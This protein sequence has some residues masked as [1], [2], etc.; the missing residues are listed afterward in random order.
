MPGSAEPQVHEPG[1]RIYGS[2][3]A[4]LPDLLE[5][6]LAAPAAKVSEHPPIPEAPGIYLFS[7]PGEAGGD[8]EKAIYVGQTR[9]LRSRLKNHTRLGGKNNEATFAF[10]LAKTDAEAG[11]IDT[12]QYREVLE[13]DK[14]FITHFDGA[15]SRVAEMQVRFILLDGPIERSLFEIY[16]AMALD[17]LVYNSFETH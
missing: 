15:K 2:V 1:I 3:V 5:K 13:Q 16:A 6:L 17:T 7:E 4:R 11:G 8:G 14:D 12:K 9:K 10:L